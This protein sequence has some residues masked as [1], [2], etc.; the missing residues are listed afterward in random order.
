MTKFR[1]WREGSVHSADKKPQVYRDSTDGKT[2]TRMVPV[3]KDVVKTA[4]AVE[5]EELTA[6]EKKLVNQMYDKKGN[7]TPLGKKVMNHG[8]KPGDRGYVENTNE[9]VKLDEL[10]TPAMKKAGNELSVYAKKSG[11]IDKA[12]FT[13]AADMLTSGKAGMPFIKFVNG[14]DTEVFEKIIT[15]MSK[16]MGRQTVEKM[17]KVKVRE[18]VVKTNEVST[19]TLSNY[20]RKSAADAG[21]PNTSARQQDKR[22]GGQ[23]MADDKLRKAQGYGSAAKVAAK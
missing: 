15:V 6:A 22:I 11:G 10:A 2:K 13:K 9:S 17:F 12:D 19:K 20:M 18:E 4:E 14:Q 1:H 3:D 16:H 5:I 21:K 23:K 8:K 7:L